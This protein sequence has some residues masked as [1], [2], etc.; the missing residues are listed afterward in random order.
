[1]QESNGRSPHGA[2]A[3]FSGCGGNDLGLST[4]WTD[5]VS[6]LGYS[7]VPFMRPVFDN[8][9]VDESHHRWAIRDASCRGAFR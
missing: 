5:P 8:S 2:P 1:M 6:Y 3:V 7:L 4:G 9:I